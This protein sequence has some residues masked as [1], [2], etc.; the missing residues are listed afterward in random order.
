SANQA[1]YAQKSLA[2]AGLADRVEVRL[3]DYREVDD[4]PYDAIASIGM[5]E[6]VGAR[7]APE[8]FGGLHDLLAPR[9][10]LL[11]HAISRPPAGSSSIDRDSFIARYV[12]PDGELIE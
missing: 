6:H 3:Q 2:E 5:F 10:R 1:D 8:Y 12:F 9:G 11:N 7:R 4:G